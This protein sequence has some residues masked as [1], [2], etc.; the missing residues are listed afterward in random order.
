MASSRDDSSFSG[1]LVRRGSTRPATAGRVG[2]D[3]LFAFERGPYKSLL[4][5]AEALISTA[6]ELVVRER[7]EAARTAAARAARVAQGLGALSFDPPSFDLLALPRP[8][9]LAVFALVPV[10]TRLRCSEVN[11]AWRALLADPSLYSSLDLSV[12]GGLTRFSL[13]LF[14]AAVVKAGGQLRSVDMNGRGWDVYCTNQLGPEALRPALDAPSL[15]LLKLDAFTDNKE[16]ALPYLCNDP[17]WAS[18]RLSELHLIDTCDLET[19]ESV[20]A[21]CAGL[22]KHPS[23]KSLSV[24]YGYFDTAPKMRAL[25]DAAIAIELKA[26]NLSAC[27]VLHATVPELTRL[28]S[29]GFVRKLILSNGSEHEQMFETGVDTNAFCTAVRS[30]LLTHL[31]VDETGWNFHQNPDVEKAVTFINTR[32]Q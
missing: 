11:R 20:E 2:G 29:A 32:N 31:E 18:L 19:L 24:H 6:S 22:R 16:E 4:R 28:V 8:L 21:F 12:T 14:R 26:V 30:S 7:P 9:A 13:P 17:P 27:S 5:T 25:V 3:S 23:L 15:K 10:D 1:Q